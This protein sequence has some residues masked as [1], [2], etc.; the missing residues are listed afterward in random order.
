[1]NGLLFLTSEDFN[2]GDGVK[3][4]ILCHGINAFSLILFYST[5]CVHCEALIPIF[6]QLPGTIIGCQIGI[7][8]VSTNKKVLEMA[9]NTISPIEYVP[10]IVL[11]VN[12]RPYMR[13]NGPRDINEIRKFVYEV[14]KNI[15]NNQAF[16]KDKVKEPKSGRGIPQYCI[17]KP[18]YG[19][20][21]VCYLKESEAY[22]K[23]N[24][25]NNRNK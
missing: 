18:L 24:N 1:M 2:I 20:D 14:T 6:H 3:G 10:Y 7:I 25:I 16:S 11:Y 21:E 22:P 8:N 13:Y 17:G 15:K 9:K 12:K 19:E 5:K 23:I 4:P